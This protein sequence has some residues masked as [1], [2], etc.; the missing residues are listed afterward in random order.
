MW[1]P[2]L[3][4]DRRDAPEAPGFGNER[5]LEGV[6]HRVS[7]T[8]RGNGNKN[9]ERDS[10]TPKKS[11][12]RLEALAHADRAA[13]PGDLATNEIEEKSAGHATD[14]RNADQWIQ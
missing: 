13:A 2:M 10:E 12:F 9:Q 1:R 7:V 14:H 8:T 5:R 3:E 4:N 11:L 6:C